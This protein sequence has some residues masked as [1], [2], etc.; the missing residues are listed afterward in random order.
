MAKHEKLRGGRERLVD[1]AFRL[2][3]AWLLCAAWRGQRLGPRETAIPDYTM[4]TRTELQ[5]HVDALREDFLNA[6]QTIVHL[7][8]R[9]KREALAM[10]LAAQF[11]R[12]QEYGYGVMMLCTAHDFERTFGPI[13]ER[14]VLE[15]P[16]YAELIM[17]GSHGLAVRHPEYMLSR[18]LS[19][20]YGL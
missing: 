16:P 18:D 20:L 2:K 9:R 15:V 13:A 3:K 8:T 17:Q 14:R 4:W 12:W 7:P 10:W 11:V 19:L 5:A 6:A 1:E